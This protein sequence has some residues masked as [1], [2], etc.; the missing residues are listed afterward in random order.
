MFFKV[1]MLLVLGYAIKLSSS[2]MTLHMKKKFYLKVKNEVTLK[3]DQIYHLNFDFVN[4]YLLY[5]KFL[6]TKKIARIRISKHVW[7]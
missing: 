6:I 3:A 4:Y 5:K 1:N 2:L 7:L